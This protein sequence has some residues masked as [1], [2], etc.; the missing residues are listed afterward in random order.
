MRNLHDSLEAPPPPPPVLVLDFFFSYFLIH[1]CLST[2][3]NGRRSSGSFR[4]SCAVSTELSTSASP[5]RGRTRVIRSAASGDTESGIFRSTFLIRR[6]VAVSVSS[7]F[8]L[9]YEKQEEE[10]QRIRHAGWTHLYALPCLR[11]AAIRPGI[12]TSIRPRP[13]DLPWTCAPYPRP[14]LA[15]GS[16]AFHKA[17]A[18]CPVSRGS[19][20]IHA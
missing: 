9:P 5:P 7:F 15:G 8:L 18:V 2:S 17:C 20:G 12:H 1:G 19:L 14:S 3:D 10:S 13:R 4:R 11:M 16:R 6:Y